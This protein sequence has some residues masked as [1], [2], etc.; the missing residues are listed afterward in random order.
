MSSLPIVDVLILGGGHAG[1]AAAL[2]LYRALHTCL[3]FDSDNPRNRWDTP[4]HLT[5]GFENQSSSEVRRKCR[6][7]LS[8]SSLISFV[9]TLID[10]IARTED[11]LFCLSDGHGQK[12]QGR[13]V[14]L[15]SGAKDVYPDIKGYEENFTQTM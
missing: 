11:G 12:W 3:V 9:D 2:S 4:I 5:P 10:T 7:E 13:A 15:A 8:Q 14:L 1:L 6:A